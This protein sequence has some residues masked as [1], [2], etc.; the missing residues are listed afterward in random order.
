LINHIKAIQ[1][2]WSKTKKSWYIIDNGQQTLMKIES[3]FKD[4]AVL[5]KSLSKKPASNLVHTKSDYTDIIEPYIHKLKRKRYSVNTIKTYKYLFTDF[6]DYFSG[7][8][9]T[10]LTEKEIHQYLT[11]KIIKE[12][13]SPSTQNQ[14]I[15][16]IKFYYEKV[17]G[18]DRKTYYID[19]PRKERKLP[20]VLSRK[21]LQMMIN[22]PGN[23]KHRLIIA[24][25]YSLGLRRSELIHMRMEDVDFDNELIFIRQAKGRKDRVNQMPGI[26]K[27]M[28]I[29][30]VQ[31]YKPRYWLIEG[32]AGKQYSESSIASIVKTASRKSGIKKHVTPHVLRHSYATHLLEDGVDIR[33]VQK[34]LGHNSIKTTQ[35]YTHISDISLRR[36]INPLDRIFGDN[37]L[38]NR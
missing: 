27:N 23:L 31:L 15:N 8:D 3:A 12:K 29:E 36:I 37:E 22:S 18:K 7:R 25:L 5:K 4:V 17:L 14:L 26:L 32:V 38:D 33:F 21:E 1:G 30:Y 6:I 2:Y 10:S 24:M 16:S 19:R 20:V 13:I 28:L 11:R 35:K 34:L 9:L